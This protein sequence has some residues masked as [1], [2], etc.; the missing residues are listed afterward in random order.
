MR[1][2]KPQK[3]IINLSY[4]GR[5]YD[6]YYFEVYCNDKR[7]W[8]SSIYFDKK[9]GKKQYD[10][11]IIYTI[12]IENQDCEDY[13]EIYEWYGEL[14]F[15]NITIEYKGNFTYFDYKSYK[16]KIINEINYE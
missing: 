2:L 5:L 3:I 16:S 9:N 4:V 14:E 8:A 15:N 7:G 11:T 1:K 6:D 10:G 13:I 12:D